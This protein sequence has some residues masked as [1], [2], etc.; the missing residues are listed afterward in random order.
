MAAEPG[1]PVAAQASTLAAYLQ[2]PESPQA[3]PEYSIFDQ[4]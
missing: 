3:S 2:G 4:P 1:Q